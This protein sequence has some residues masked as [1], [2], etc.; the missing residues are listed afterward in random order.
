MGWFK[1][2]IG[3]E[4]KMELLRGKCLTCK[5]ICE[6]PI[7]KGIH[8]GLNYFCKTT[9]K[10]GKKMPSMVFISCEDVK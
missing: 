6:W 3:I 7:P 5:K 9:K 1:K 2:L 4:P 10:C 8:Y